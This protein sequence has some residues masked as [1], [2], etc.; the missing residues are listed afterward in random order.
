MKKVEL[1]TYEDARKDV[2]EGMTDSEAVVR[3][4]ES[5][6]QALREIEEVTLQMTPFCEKHIDFECQGCPLLSYDFPCSDS[7]STYAIFYQELRKLRMIAE[8][9]LA[10]LVAVRRNEEHKNSFFV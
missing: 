5:I 1:Y 6:I 4:W 2:E 7:F 10:T 9:L 3:K 8:N